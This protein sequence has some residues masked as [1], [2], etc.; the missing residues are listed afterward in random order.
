M[1]GRVLVWN[2]SHPSGTR[3]EIP[4]AFGPADARTGVRV[5][6][7]SAT[8]PAPSCIRGPER[9]RGVRRYGPSEVH[10]SGKFRAVILGVRN[11]LTDP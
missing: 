10:V 3:T 9:L 4:G 2:R 8:H 6:S 5:Y 11:V 1:T 7:D